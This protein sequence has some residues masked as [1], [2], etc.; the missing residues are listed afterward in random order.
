MEEKIGVL[1]IFSYICTHNLTNHTTQ[2]KKHCIVRGLGAIAVQAVAANIDYTRRLTDGVSYTGR[3]LQ[4][5]DGSVSYDWVG[6][7]VQTEF[8]GGT[9]AVEMAD[10]KVSYHNVFIDDQWVDKIRVDST[11]RQRIVLAKNLDKRPHRLRLQRACEGGGRTTVYGF[12]VPRGGT[13]AAVAPR[14]RM[15]EVYGDSYT[16]GYGSDSPD[17]K[18]HFKI[19][20]EN[21]DHAY[22]CI[23]ARYFGAD[24]AI[25]AH[26]GQGMVR[27][28]NDKKQR[29]D[30]TMLNR[31]TQVFDNERE[32]AYTFDRYQPSLIM[33]NLGT[34]DFSREVQPRPNQYTDNYMKMIRS[35]RSHYGNEV[36]ILCILPHSASKYLQVS[37][38]EL[39]KCCYA[40]KQVYF[41]EPMLEILRDQR[42]FGADGHPNYQGHRKIAMKLIPQISRIMNWD[43]EDKVVK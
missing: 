43:M 27:N 21:V 13:L 31:H 1:K 4:Q 41:A 33:I 17:H 25:Q 36:P 24:Y 5:A 11:G 20:S 15:I 6:V 23:I 26:S 22:S 35:L 3:T 30:Y 32:P 29:S 16:C 42:D 14:E 8:T 9:I 12:Y 39:R 2:M 40:D 10:T 19:E 34:N 37:F 7:Y 28:F 18:E 38:E